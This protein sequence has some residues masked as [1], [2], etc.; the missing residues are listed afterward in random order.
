MRALLDANILAGPLLYLVYAVAAALAIVVAIGV[1]G[2]LGSRRVWALRVIA[3]ATVGGATGLVLSWLVADVWNLFGAPVSAP[4][5]A[6]SSATLAGIAV[7]TNAF[8]RTRW[9]TKV[10]AAVAIFAILAAG[11]LGIN[12]D[13]GEYH[14][15]RS[16]FSTQI[17]PIALPSKP[18]AS[19]LPSP[20]PD[21]RPLW[22]SWTPPA[23][24][25]ASGQLG[26]M[27]IPGVVSKFPAR[28]A[29]LYLPPAALVADPPPLPVVIALSGQPGQPMN[30]F[31]TA[32]L[33]SM[34]EEFQKAHDGL[35]PIVIAPDQ[36]G[37]PYANPMCVDSP[38]GNSATYL[39]V[40][41]PAWIRSHLHVQSGPAS[42]A[43]GG[44]SQGGTC[45]IQLGAAH[46]ELFG[47]ILDVSGEL[48]PRN[49]TPQH[50]IDVGF[51]GDAAAYERAK[52]VNILAAHAPYSN[53]T[54]IFAVGQT[55]ARYT[56]WEHEMAA[57]AQAAGMT[58]TF[59]V[60]PG[61]GHDWHTAS[62]ALAA[63]MRI[64]SAKFGLAS[65]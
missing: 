16:V 49:G 32:N 9:W 52:P 6:W 10:T 64:L 34:L 24:M 47:A 29:V 33:H 31:E 14:S 15:L 46:P 55:D 1:F 40:D 22:Q 25:P 53:M 37:A 63:G 11:L 50:T 36:L 4:T 42:W 30:V 20:V 59:I 61:T 43:I 17:R 56:P 26:G 45:A 39:T 62:Y 58:T 27:S 18:A 19:P 48:V 8:W 65:Q 51:G 12:A 54:A 5:Q 38:L 3:A 41:V 44:F 28:Q 2:R 57:A 35:S 23:D 13:I 60:A 21:T 7:A